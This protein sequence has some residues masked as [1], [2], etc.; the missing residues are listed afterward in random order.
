MRLHPTAAAPPVEYHPAEPPR[1][2]RYTLV[3][4]TWNNLPFLRLCLESLARNS[5]YPQ[6][7]VV[8]V[9]EGVDGTAEWVREQGIAHTYSA[10]NA[11]ICW[12]LNAAASLARTDLIAYANDDMYFCPGWDAPLLE[13]GAAMGHDLWFHSGTMIEPVGAFPAALAPHDFGRHPD[14]F[15]ERELL[16]ALPSLRKEDWSGA[17]VP[18]SLVPRR[19]WELAGGYSPELSPG[20]ASDW[21]FSMKLWRAGVRHF[22]GFGASRV[23]HFRKISTS[24]L[25]VGDGRALFARK[26][27]IPASWFFWKA[28]RHGQPWSGPLPEM[29]KLPDWRWAVFKAK[30]YRFVPWSS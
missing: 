19:L 13:A 16:A 23:Y 9:N 4:P 25:E 17:T 14:A 1:G 21:D 5:S 26:W 3:I 15:R 10:R 24:R 18:P 28:L 2:A 20:A 29:E 12:S 27:G 30:R 11:G 8:H 7:L 22:R 6:Q